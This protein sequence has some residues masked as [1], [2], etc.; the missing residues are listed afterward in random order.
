MASFELIVKVS[1]ITTRLSKVIFLWI[2]VVTLF[3]GGYVEGMNDGV[4]R[5]ATA[6]THITVI[7]GVS[8]CVC[9]YGSSSF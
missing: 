1:R 6:G 7:V 2:D 4:I 3:V 9:T 8:L 5:P